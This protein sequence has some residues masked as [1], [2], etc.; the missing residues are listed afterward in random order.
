MVLKD[1]SDESKADAMALC[2]STPGGT[3]K[4]IA[5]DLGVSRG[6]LREWV[7]RVLAPAEARR[8]PGRRP[9]R[10]PPAPGHW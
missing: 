1:Y 3:Y 9:R 6:S 7:L 10:R 2:E 8:R 5:A 4:D